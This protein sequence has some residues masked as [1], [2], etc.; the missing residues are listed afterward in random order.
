[1]MKD[2]VRFVVIA[3]LCFAFVTADPIRC[4]TARQTFS[5]EPSQQNTYSLRESYIGA[6]EHSPVFL[7]LPSNPS[8]GYSW[9]ISSDF[10][11]KFVACS[12]MK[13]QQT[14]FRVGVA[15][16]ELWQ[17][18]TGDVGQTFE[19]ILQYKRPWESS[20]VQIHK[21]NVEVLPR[22]VVRVHNP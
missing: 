20:A 17:F 16:N 11:S 15:G 21:W 6:S 4:S 18:T 9:T 3:A 22:A 12:F 1:M 2:V 5:A 14:Q 8:T 19:I 13:P 10:Q 7:F